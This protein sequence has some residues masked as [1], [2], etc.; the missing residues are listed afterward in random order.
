MGVSPYRSIAMASVCCALAVLSASSCAAQDQGQY[1][2]SLLAGFHWRDVGPMRGGRSY[3][4]AGVP[5]R[6]EER[7]VGKE[8]LE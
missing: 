4:V 7:R 2:T 3:G 6:S 8:C 1:P 5:S